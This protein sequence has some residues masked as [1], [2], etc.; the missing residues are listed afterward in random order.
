MAM[1]PL[2]QDLYLSTKKY[3]VMN[4]CCKAAKSSQLMEQMAIY[5]DSAWILT[6]TL[7]WW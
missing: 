4:G 3:Q 7:L 6:I 2:R 5:L 1:D